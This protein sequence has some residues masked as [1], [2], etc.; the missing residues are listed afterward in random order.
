MNCVRPGI[1][2]TGIHARGGQPDRIARIAPRVPMARAGTPDEVAQAILWL[3][4][5]AA[6]YVTDAILDVSGGR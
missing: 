6:S 3:L 4:S 2:D 5:D 1:I